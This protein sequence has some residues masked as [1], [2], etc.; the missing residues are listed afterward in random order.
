MRQG[1]LLLALVV[2][3]MLSCSL[4]LAACAGPEATEDP[5]IVVSSKTFVEALIMGNMTLQLLEARGFPVEDEIGL[6][7]V[8]TMRPA[9]TGGQVDLYWEYTGTVL[10]TVMDAEPEADSQAVF[11]RVRDWDQEENNLVWLDYAPAN[12][13]HVMFVAPELAE[14]QELETISDLGELLEEQDL[15]L[16]LPTEWYERKDGLEFFEEHYDLEFPRDEL[17]FVELGL[18]YQAVDQDEAEVGI[19]DAT[20]ARLAE[21]D[22]VVLED[23][24]G[25]FPAY[26]PAPVVRAEILEAY[27]ELAAVMQELSGLLD[28]ETLTQLNY[29]VAVEDR[30]PEEVAGEFLQEQGLVD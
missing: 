10:M 26:N 2:L 11:E 8:A 4:M 29:Q 21:F 30:Q 7:E 12:N 28:E 20:D 6:G 5:P 16:A 15:R 19:G 25:F 14:E 18:A 22:L 27:P 9:I 3:A 13:T 17:Q 1:R 24:Q 23:D